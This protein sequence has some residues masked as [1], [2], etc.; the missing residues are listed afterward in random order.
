MFLRQYFIDAEIDLKTEK[1]SLRVLSG[2]VSTTRGEKI[3]STQLSIY[4]P[5]LV[6]SNK[7]Q[8]RAID[9]GGILIPKELIK[10]PG[11]EDVATKTDLSSVQNGLIGD[12]LAAVVVGYA[13]SVGVTKIEHLAYILATCEHES[14]MGIYLKE[15]GDN[16]YFTR[17]YEGRE[18][19]G[20]NQPGDGAKYCGRGLVQCTGRNNYG[21][22]SKKLGID[23]VGNPDLASDLKNAVPMLV[24][25][26]RDGGYTGLK[27][28]DSDRATG[29]DYWLA[30]GII[31]GTDRAD[32]IA[33]IAKK[34]YQRLQSGELKTDTQFKNDISVR[35]EV[36]K[37]LAPKPGQAGTALSQIGLSQ[38]SPTISAETEGAIAN[39]V[40]E[41]YPIKITLSSNDP[42][43][44]PLSFNY[45]LY[46]YEGSGDKL[47]LGARG[48]GYQIHE[49]TKTK[50]TTTLNN[51]SI[52]TIARNVGIQLGLKVEIEDTVLA[53]KLHQKIVQFKG[54]SLYQLLVR[55]GRLDGLHVRITPGNVLKIE[56]IYSDSR[57]IALLPE[58]FL[59][60][61]TFQETAASN[62]ILRQGLPPLVEG[63]K[64]TV[65]SET[66]EK[67]A[68]LGQTNNQLDAYEKTVQEGN[69]IG[70]GFFCS[71][72]L[73]SNPLLWRIQPEDI[74]T[75]PGLLVTGKALN[76]EYK[77]KSLGHNFP[78][79][80]TL[81]ELYIPVWE[82]K[83]AIATNEPTQQVVNPKI[84]EVL[85]VAESY[86][87]LNFNSDVSAQCAVFVRH[88]FSKAGIPLGVTKNPVDNYLPTYESLANSLAGSDIGTVNKD[89][90]LVK[91]GDMVFW[92]NTYG[93]F[94]LGTITHTGISVGNG[95]IIDRSTSGAPVKKRS[96]DTF[97]QFVCSVTVTGIT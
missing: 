1:I 60:A 18:D 36:Q 73:V 10:P 94:P 96:I 83:P 20:N 16:A 8:Q 68:I 70:E 95:L 33:G 26:M 2:K 4:D 85:K 76:R 5:G 54:E 75:L 24:I 71:C 82:E 81:L 58:W 87:G 88:C 38:T 15:I 63:F 91:A 32:L 41:G 44:I 57:A 93:S 9:E 21:K 47:T 22:W 52:G 64:R 86:V 11:K 97:T 45:F 12:P 61:P 79:N 49:A 53:S 17:L 59:E 7:L 23:L 80:T 34:Y 37:A 3:S 67:L 42:K 19:L 92:A 39:D 29:Y 6:I 14:K 35:V 66:S 40:T 46:S 48:V 55:T 74:V 31:N 69:A 65:K 51:T 89:K 43:H 72:T 84:S 13:K 27:L 62:R 56:P 90:S 50:V 30:R 28:S 25:G 77:V 78:Q